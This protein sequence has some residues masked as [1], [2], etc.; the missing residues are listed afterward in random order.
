MRKSCGTTIDITK[1]PYAAKC[2]ARHITLYPNH[3][4]AQATVAQL[5]KVGWL[6][7]VLDLRLWHNRPHGV[8]HLK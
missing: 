3:D 4:E 6:R 1:R 5:S 8:H 2:K 7:L